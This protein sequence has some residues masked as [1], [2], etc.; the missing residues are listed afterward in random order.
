MLR[1]RGM[2][3]VTA[4]IF[5]LAPV[6]KTFQPASTFPMPPGPDP[7]PQ[8]PG[9][10]PN[11]QPPG[12]DPDQKPAMPRPRRPPPRRPP[13]RQ[14]THRRGNMARARI[15]LVVIF[16]LNRVLDFLY[17]VD[18]PSELNRPVLSSIITSAIWTT[19]LLIG[20]ALRKAWA[21]LIFLGLLALSVVFILIY[22]PT[23]FDYPSLMLPLLA[24]LMVYAG[25]F[26]WLIFSRD[27][28][29]L[30]SRERE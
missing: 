29:R 8:P 27:V 15:G 30:T 17:L 10:D 25:S 11:P 19:A 28:H 21:R 18:I 3:F 26:A 20:I 13:P 1:E 24:S 9:P 2:D 7:N 16:V 12:P 4:R 23:A 5:R 6:E 14:R 22:F